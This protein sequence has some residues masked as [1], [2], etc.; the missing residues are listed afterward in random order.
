[1]NVS[2]IPYLAF[3]GNCREAVQRYIDIFGG[4][5]L[6][7]SKWDAGNCE[8]PAWRG[9]VMHVEFT[10]GNTRMGGGDPREG[11]SASDMVKL[12]VH[13]EDRKS[14]EEKVRLLADGGEVLSPLQPHPKPDD[15]GMGA[16][17]CDAYGYT[18]I[19]TAP[20]DEKPEA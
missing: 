5:I 10:L 17:I 3:R 1:M 18:W 4:E 15:G 14:A 16:L 13:F 9:K 6:Y 8:D 12:M 11:A 7:L 20:N 2:I 19:I